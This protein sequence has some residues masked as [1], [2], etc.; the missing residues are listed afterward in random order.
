LHYDRDV[1]RVFR[2]RVH[3]ATLLAA[4][5][6]AV[7]P[8][9]I[10][11]QPASVSPARENPYRPAALEPRYRFRVH[12]TLGFVRGIAQTPD[13]YLWFA[14][15]FG[16][17]RYD[18]VTF[19]IFDTSNTPE[20][21]E[22][23]LMGLVLGSDGALWFPS[24]RSGLV[25]FK[26]G[27]FSRIPLDVGDPK[28]L[29]QCLDEDDTGAMWVGTHVGLFRYQP[30]PQR[31]QRFT[32]ADGLPD[33]DVRELWQTRAGELLGHA[34]GTWFRIRK[35]AIT[36]TSP[37]AEGFS[38]EAELV[39]SAVLPPGARPVTDSHYDEIRQHH[40][41]ALWADGKDVWIA[42]GA[43]L[44]HVNDHGK[45]LFRNGLASLNILGVF[46]DRE[47]NVWVGHYGSGVTQMT[48]PTFATFG[49]RDGLGGGAPF[50]SAQTR[51]ETVWV[52]VSGLLTE[53]KD[54]LFRNHVPGEGVPT[55]S[56]RSTA[57][58]S[59]DRL[60]MTTVDGPL[61]G[62]DGVRFITVPLP[63]D[64]LPLEFLSAVHAARGDV[65]W[66]ASGHGGLLWLEDA[67]G[68]SP[69]LQRVA[70]PELGG[71]GCP[72]PMTQ[73]YPCPHA[74]NV[75]ADRR[76][77]GLWL[78]TFGKGLW[79][80]DAGGRSHAI[81]HDG[82]LK[83]TVFAL[84]EEDGGTLWAG[85]DR[86]LFRVHGDRVRARFGREHG[87]ASDGVFEIL[88]DGLGQLWIGC[89]RGVYSVKKSELA[90]VEARTIKT[91]DP[92]GYRA[93]DGLPS[94][95]VIRRYEPVGLRTRDGRLWFSTVAGLAIFDAPESLRPTAPPQALLERI[96]LRRKEVKQ[97]F[98][99]E[100]IEIPP[101][102]G[103][104]EF[105]YTAPAFAA[106]HRVRFKYRLDGF[107]RDWVKAGGR[108]AAFYTN[109][110][111]GSYSFRVVADSAE[112][113]TSD[114]PAVVR[115]VLRPAFHQT[116]WFYLTLA[117][118]AL[119]GAVTVQK[120]RIRQ[121]QARFA[122]VLDERN[123]IARDLHD[124]LAQVFSAIGFQIDSAAGL[125]GNGSPV[126]TDRLRRVRQMVAHARLAARNVIWNL[127]REAGDLP[128]GQALARMLEA[129]PP[130]YD[131]A[132]VA[133]SV[134]GTAVPLPPSV[135]NELFH[136]GQEAVSNAIEHG[137]AQLVSIELVYEV[138]RVEMWIH[139]DG[140]GFEPTDHA[141]ADEPRFGL[142]GM[143]ERATRIGARFA[144][145][146]EPGVGT[147]IEVVVNL[148]ASEREGR[149]VA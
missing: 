147:E 130:L 101:G 37:E 109:I 127:R 15:S 68:P 118:L 148:P 69:H 100:V 30:A 46:R 94:D 26:D 56:V 74:V 18:G 67:H 20:I 138:D 136:I 96:V 27:R 140:Q 13:G 121:V 62:Y 85:T 91:V 134:A 124:T 84:R 99:E 135:E 83:A 117:A 71:F 14:T 3:E 106:P 107:D 123:R 142:R 6:T 63:K 128:P 17:A 52:T 44:L 48:K 54:G 116:I 39:L 112:S 45:H 40:V 90:A 41:V 55:Y 79:Y 80:R 1:R 65:V 104:L 113:G 4:L 97:P 105:H 29:I 42:T 78:G 145:H 143:K 12:R 53:L 87:L 10:A 72:G 36:V 103:D 92:V 126:L 21:P 122:A 33:N 137:R 28:P 73:D 133:V 66:G 146:T 77:G 129:I 141:A 119:V 102:S 8:T 7:S 114:A 70:V 86:G 32:S 2:L 60:W 16:L 98:P 24:G 31:W 59:S 19:T 11:A 82:L 81:A 5:A 120:L 51:D 144:V 131:S 125:A 58:T 9:R 35:G 149:P 76:A 139:D 115:F 61:I 23:H 50:S 22:D 64:H 89:E 49:L 75:I 57:V 95:E 108:R 25:R 110:P 34:G 132:N 47:G 38:H 43:G 88:E 111:P 93:I